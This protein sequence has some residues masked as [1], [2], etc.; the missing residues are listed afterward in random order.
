MDQQDNGHDPIA[1]CVLVGDQVCH[2]GNFEYGLLQLHPH[3]SRWCYMDFA[4]L[5]NDKHSFRRCLVGKQICSRGRLGD[6][7]QLTGWSELDDAYTMRQCRLRSIFRCAVGFCNPRHQCHAE[8]PRGTCAFAAGHR[9]RRVR[10]SPSPSRPPRFS[11]RPSCGCRSSSPELE[12][13]VQDGCGIPEHSRIARL[14]AYRFKAM[15]GTFM[16]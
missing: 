7:P 15:A 9:L 6:D 10:P 11:S 12:E 13:S 16:T 8:R 1:G 2:S 4:N 5:R 14:G 3:L